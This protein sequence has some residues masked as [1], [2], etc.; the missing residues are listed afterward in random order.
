MNKAFDGYNLNSES[1][2]L[3]GWTQRTGKNRGRN[4]C[5][6]S[7]KKRIHNK[8]YISNPSEAVQ[9]AAVQQNGYAIKYISNPSEAV[10]LAIKC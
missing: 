7:S 5:C 9:L 3:N 2:I 1:K 8:K 6:I 4:G 10:K